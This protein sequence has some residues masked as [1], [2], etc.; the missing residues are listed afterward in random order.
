MSNVQPLPCAAFSQKGNRR[1]EAPQ[2]GLTTVCAVLCSMPEAGMHLSCEVSLE[3]KQQM[4]MK[5]H[6]EM[7]IKSTKTRIK[8]LGFFPRNT[9]IHAHALKCL[10]SV[11]ANTPCRACAT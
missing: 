1:G 10:L 4:E 11:K 7:K 2:P 3:E 5:A 6:Y 8:E 9:L